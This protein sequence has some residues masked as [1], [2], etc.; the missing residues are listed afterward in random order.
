METKIVHIGEGKETL[1]KVP[2]PPVYLTEDAKK[3][4]LKMGLILAKH[5]LLKDKF[6]SALEVYAE[7]M[8]QWE[9]SIRRIK[10]KN[11]DKI[12]AG[13]IQKF[14][15]GAENISVEI[16]LKNDAEATLFK[17]F[18]IFGLDPKSEK[19]LKNT[20]DPNQ[21][22]LFEQLMKSRSS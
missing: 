16:T 15:S 11:K 1:T 7:A 4:F 9:F 5:D 3:H 17:C 13:Y 21:V 12:G 10:E 2:K 22:N 14:K 20:T 19:E 6:L 18:K 8:A